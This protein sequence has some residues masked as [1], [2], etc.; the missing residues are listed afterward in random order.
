MQRSVG[1]LSVAG[2]A[3]V[4]AAGATAE[5]KTYLLQPDPDAVFELKVQKT[6]L[7]AGKVHTFVFS[8]FEGELK[9]DPAA[10]DSTS[11]RLIVESDSIE[12]LDDWVSEKDRGKILQE[13]RGPMLAVEK[14][15]ELRFEA[16]GLTLGPEGDYLAEGLLTIRDKTQTTLVRVKLTG[17]GEGFW[18][19]G[20]A[21]VSLKDYGLKPP[22][23]ALGL[24]GTKSEMDVRFALCAAPAKE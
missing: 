15:P 19:E 11:V 8:R 12:C 4:F 23:A 17:A 1:A 3:L 22:S 18:V 16:D 14:Y 13:A 20:T 5:P 9:Y 6:G 24:I 10:P 7:M 21:R 2:L